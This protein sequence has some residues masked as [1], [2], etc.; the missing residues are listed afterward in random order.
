MGPS[1]RWVLQDSGAFPDL[2]EVDQLTPEQ[3]ALGGGVDAATYLVRCPHRDVVVK[4]KGNGLEAEAR[5]LRAWRPYTTRVHA[6]HRQRHGRLRTGVACVEAPAIYAG[7]VAA[8]RPCQPA[9]HQPAQCRPHGRFPSA[10]PED[11]RSGLPVARLLG[12]WV[13]FGDGELVGGPRRPS[14]RSPSGWC[15]WSKAPNTLGGSEASYE[16]SSGTR[17]ADS[18][19][20]N[21]D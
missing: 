17:P 20:R 3:V 1:L 6:H 19:E 9:I 7:P 12:D 18:L 5:A 15:Q 4:L 8:S 2:P 16:V 21:C 14:G 13:R 10:H 11:L